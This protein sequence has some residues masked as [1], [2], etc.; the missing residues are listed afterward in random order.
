LLEN[1]N[2]YVVHGYAYSN[3]LQQLNPPSEVFG[4]GGSLDKAFEGGC[5]MG[6]CG[7]SGRRR[8]QQVDMADTELCIQLA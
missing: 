6:R 2:E 3:Y 5:L 4:K 7:W 8:E 1:A